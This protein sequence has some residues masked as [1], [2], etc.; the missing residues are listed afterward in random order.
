MNNE[1]LVQFFITELYTKTD[2]VQIQD[3]EEEFEPDL[4]YGK[5][6]LETKEK[7]FNEIKNGIQSNGYNFSPEQELAFFEEK[8]KELFTLILPEIDIYISKISVE[9]R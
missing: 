5:H 8:K 9:Y 6:I 7:L 4:E 2:F 3:P 1:H